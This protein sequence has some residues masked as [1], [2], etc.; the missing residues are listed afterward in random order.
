MGCC[1]LSCSLDG[2]VGAEREE[3]MLTTLLA[4]GLGLL[5]GRVGLLERG[6]HVAGDGCDRS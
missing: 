2:V 3:R 1:L 4:V 5:I 6:G